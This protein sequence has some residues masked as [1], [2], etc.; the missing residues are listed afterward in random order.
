MANE[1]Q[2]SGQLNVAKG[3]LS[4]VHAVSGIHTLN[5]ASPAKAAGIAAIGTSQEAVSIG[6]VA[7]AGW[8]MFKNLDSTN[9]LEIGIEITGTFFPFLKLKAGEA[10]GPLRLGVNSIYARAN[11]AACKLQYDIYDD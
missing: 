11:T 5:A 6:D 10:A 4:A 9:Y 3:N 1:I 2:V 7:T 8:A